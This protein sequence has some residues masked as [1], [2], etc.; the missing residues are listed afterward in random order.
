M[1]KKKY[2]PNLMVLQVRTDH[3]SSTHYGK[4]GC[5][6]LSS[7]RKVVHVIATILGEEGSSFCCNLTR[8]DGTHNTASGATLTATVKMYE[9]LLPGDAYIDINAFQQTWGDQYYTSGYCWS[10][11]YGASIRAFMP[12]DTSISTLGLYMQAMRKLQKVRDE[13]MNSLN[14]SSER[15]YGDVWLMANYLA[16]AYGVKKAIL[17][18]TSDTIRQ[19]EY[20]QFQSNA[21]DW[22]ALQVKLELRLERE[23]VSMEE[24]Y[25]VERARYVE[26]EASN[27][28]SG[29][30]QDH[31]G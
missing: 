6:N 12:S 1:D 31:N 4:D 21:S 14:G 2:K 5:P 29:L 11:G 13:Y 26:W 20:K 19:V 8:D 18:D 28:S 17:I 7:T 3:Q 25:A 22:A 10:N 24:Q 27:Q 30:A 15:P 23:W 16:N 9:S